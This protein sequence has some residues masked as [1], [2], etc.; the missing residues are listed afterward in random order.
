MCIWYVEFS[1]KVSSIV[2]QCIHSNPLLHS[3][4]F[5]AKVVKPKYSA[6]IESLWNKMWAPLHSCTQ[7]VYI[8]SDV[9]ALIWMR[10]L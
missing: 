1:L 4:S 2:N 3:S 10:N 7:S 5:Q 6:F 9:D 8:W